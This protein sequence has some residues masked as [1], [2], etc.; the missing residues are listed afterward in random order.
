MLSFQSTKCWA[1]REKG[2]I[3]TASSPKDRGILEAL[4]VLRASL[5]THA[6]VVIDHWPEDPC[7]IGVASSAERSRLVYLASSETPGLYYTELE[8]PASPGSDL[9]YTPGPSRAGVPLR[10][11]A[12]LVETHLR[13]GVA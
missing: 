9:P 4:D 7:A 3:E 5:G 6:F 1:D 13:G 2:E 8:F 12:V 10:E 11:L